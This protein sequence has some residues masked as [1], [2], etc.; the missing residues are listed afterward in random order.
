[1]RTLVLTAAL[2][3]AASL[4][5]G[6]TLAHITPGHGGATCGG[7]APSDTACTTGSHLMTWTTDMDLDFAGT[8]DYTGTLEST[9]TQGR[10]TYTLRCGFSGGVST[11]C[12]TSGTP[13]GPGATFT[14]DCRS[15]DAGTTTP[16]GS[17]PWTCRIYHTVA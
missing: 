1:M 8:G 13:P 4:V 10:N 6:P 15:H 2:A 3:L 16:G 11:G 17:G 5:P 9:L 7:T 12:S 14:H